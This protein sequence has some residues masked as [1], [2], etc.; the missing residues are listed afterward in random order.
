MKSNSK[1]RSLGHG[2]NVVTTNGRKYYSYHGKRKSSEKYQ[3]AKFRRNSRVNKKSKRNSKA[4]RPSPNKRS[5]AEQRKVNKTREKQFLRN[6]GFCKIKNR[7]DFYEQVL[8]DRKTFRDKIGEEDSS[9]L[10]LWFQIGDGHKRK[11][12][13]DKRL[14]YTHG[15]RKFVNMKKAKMFLGIGSAWY[16]R[17]IATHPLPK[18]RKTGKNS[19]CLFEKKAW[20]VVS[21]TRGTRAIAPRILKRYEIQEK[22]ER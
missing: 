16:E 15:L 5:R 1:S 18:W 11:K 7:K 2:W 12:K 10:Q 20:L 14:Q 17:S 3:S 8:K 4:K 13:A 9:G 6:A 22:L 19:V 21:R